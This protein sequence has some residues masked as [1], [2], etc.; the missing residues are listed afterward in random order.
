MLATSA[1]ALATDGS[2]DLTAYV[3]A[4]AA[5]ADGADARA[6]A[7]YAT[8]LSADPDNAVIAVRAY[9]SG[10]E[11]GDYAL[12]TRARRVLEA[13]GVPPPDV[14][15]LALAEAMKTEDEAGIEAALAEI[16]KSP[17]DFIAPSLRAWRVNEKDPKAALAILDR[18]GSNPIARRYAAETRALLMIAGGRIDNGMTLMRVLIG[19]DLGNPELRISAAQLLAGQ[20]REDLARE[21]LAGDSAEIS[22]LR[23]ALGQ[24]ARPGFAFGMARLLTRLAG[25]LGDNDTARVSIALTRAVLRVEPGNDRARLLLADALAEQGS[26]RIAIGELDQIAPDSPAAGLAQVRRVAILNEAGQPAEA[27]A[28]AN[29]VAMSPGATVQDARRQGDLLMAADRYADAAKAYATAL[30]RA[31]KQADWTLHLQHGGALDQAGR[32]P[33]ARPALERAV[34]LAPDEPL[35]LNYLGYAEIEHG[36]DLKRARTL[37][38]RASALRPQDVSILDS[39]AWA[40]FKSGETLRAL[41]LLE[42]AAQGQPANGTIIEHLGDVYWRIGRRFEARYAWRAAAVNADPADGRRIAAKLA[43]GPARN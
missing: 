27:L 29:R 32:W 30:S 15:L 14:A 25:D 16:E 35:A 6:A 39:L 13:A 34:A 37:L 1:P 12:V 22:A 43:H 41:P 31:G 33:E 38:E 4:R 11:I 5:D 26:W 9:R 3:I 2:A 10:L 24:G 19:I 40:Y 28:I 18:A 42:R 23:N 21:L 20:G 17:V 8:A 7:G 36:G